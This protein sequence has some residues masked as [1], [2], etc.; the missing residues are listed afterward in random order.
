MSSQ[1]RLHL[2][3]P[4][5]P[6]EQQAINELIELA[7]IV[8]QNQR[9]EDHLQP[10][11]KINAKLD[12]EQQELAEAINDKTPLDARSEVADIVYYAVQ[13]FYHNGDEIQLHS[14]IAKAAYKTALTEQQ[15]YV[16][17][18]AKYRLRAV[19]PKNFVAENDAIAIA[20]ANRL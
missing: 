9:G 10:V 7:L 17:A 8:A 11:E 6:T 5:F 14:D 15:A 19:N 4:T 2:Q 16:C 13:R 20:L 12:A 3:H 1:Y 18:L